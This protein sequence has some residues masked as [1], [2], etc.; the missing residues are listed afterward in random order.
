MTAPADPSSEPA[1]GPQVEGPL[2]FFHP[3]T[4]IATWF[5]SGLLPK[6]PGTWGSLAALPFAVAL[7]W[8]GGPWLLAVSA[9][10]VFLI[11]IWASDLYA[12]RLGRD[13]PG[14]V[15]VDEVAGQW[16][17]LVPVA[18]AFEYYLPG[19]LLFRLFD[20][21]KPWPVNLADR[22]L[23]GGFGIMADDVLAAV[24]AAAALSLLIWILE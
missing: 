22:K 12:R 16:L 4:L 18:L 5:G 2:A 21:L 23:K 8:L 17:T 13:D 9:V 24:Y 19:F 7:A 10:A 1:E 14:S 3:A 6:I 15:V 20:I 11:G